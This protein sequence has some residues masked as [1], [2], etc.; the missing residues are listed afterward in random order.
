MEDIRWRQRLAHYQKAL[1]Q[2]EEAVALSRQRP[3]SKLEQQGLIKGF[4]MAHELAWNLMKDWFEFQGATGITGSRDATRESFRL[5]LVQD[6][7]GWMD[8]IKSRNKTVHTYN[9]AVADEIAGLICN[10]YAELF[11]EFASTMEEREH[12]G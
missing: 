12:G 5:G 8:M 7:E 1:A 9:E 4:E 2:L 3:L 6:G 11:R 10:R